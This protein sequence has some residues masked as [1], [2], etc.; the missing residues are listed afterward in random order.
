M[1][2][3]SDLLRVG[4]MREAHDLLQAIVA[5]NPR[6]VEGLRLFAGTK[7]ALGDLAAAEEWLRKALAV[8]PNWTP[9]LGTLGEL[10][11]LSGRTAEAE[12][13]L[14]QALKGAP[15]LP[16]AA[17]LLARFYN[18]TGRSAEALCVLEPVFSSGY[19]DGDLAAQHIS[20]LGALG[21]QRDAVA[22]YQRL[23]AASPDNL[24]VTQ[25]LAVALNAAGQTGEAERVAH[26][27]LLRG[28]RTAALYNIYARSLIANGALQ[29]AEGA[30]RD[31]LKL[32]PRLLEAHNNLAQLVWIRTGDLAQ[33]T[34]ELDIVLKT[35]PND[36]SLWAAKAALLQGAGDARSAYG[37]LT[38]WALRPHASPGLLI[39]AALAALE[40]DSPAAS[41]LAE[42]ALKLAPNN[43]S[44]RTVLAA[45]QLGVGN[46]PRALQLCEGLLA[47]SPDDQ[48][49]I[50]LQTTAWRLMG[51]ER[52]AQ[53]CDYSN[54]VLPSQLEPPPP[55]TDLQS[56]LADLRA[57]LSK[58][59]DPKGHALLFQSLRNG[60][61][62]TQD[63]SRN[64]DPAIRGLFS[65]FAAPIQRYLEHIGYGADPLRR[66]NNGHW[67][68]NGSWSVR[69][70]TSGFHTSHVHPRGWISSACYIELPDCMS[71]GA[72]REGILTFGV[73]GF[74]T[75]PPLEI[76][77]YVRPAVGMLVLFPS[78]F[79][80]GTVPFSSTQPRLTVAFDAIPTGSR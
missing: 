62:T 33:A 72:S 8:D 13:S 27:T 12:A 7:Q 30:L 21:R 78:Y 25:A 1:R 19:V 47:E 45:A 75:T 68:F 34:A 59:H 55:W 22:G 26:Q 56:F 9:T 10:L 42:R 11:L 14:R 76:E 23:A 70:Q 74:P 3:I 61:E 71:D 17:F 35:Y 46:A 80:H 67:R 73:P 15:P 41:E 44:A 39:R 37:C 5:A 52:Y 32:E 60:T 65:S 29:R 50:A 38:E 4:A 69:L 24:V 49:L 36:E 58:L 53:I 18:D 48:Y 40:F 66:R 57:S 54:L 31:C 77:H 2:R 6:F 64:A 16:R 51:D 79:W 20:A 63:L 28:H 43:S